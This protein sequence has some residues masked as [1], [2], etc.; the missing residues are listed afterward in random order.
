MPVQQYQVQLVGPS[1]ALASGT[2]LYDEHADQN[3]KSLTLHYPDGEITV[4]ASDFF[5]ALCDIRTRLEANG[6]RPVCYGSS[7]N[8]YPSG[9]CRDMGR[10]LKAYRL[11]L[12]RVPTVD[13]LVPIFETG[14]D[15]EPS[16]VQEQRRFWDE[17]RKM[18]KSND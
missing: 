8:V 12:G 15:V 5:D 17:W 9:M 16:S 3:R 4:A 11:K 18:E 6:W 13:D 10:G 7:R 2:F 1:N 14:P